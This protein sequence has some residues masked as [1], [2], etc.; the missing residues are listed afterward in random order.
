MRYWLISVIQIPIPY[1]VVS[2]S[3]FKSSRVILGNLVPYQVGYKGCGVNACGSWLPLIEHNG[4]LLMRIQGYRLIIIVNLNII[5]IGYGERHVES[6]VILTLIPYS[7]LNIDPTS[8]S[9]FRIHIHGF[10]NS[11]VF[12]IHLNGH[13]INIPVV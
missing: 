11:I 13:L 5:L 7:T 9:D 3:N 1:Q 8:R 12:A 2:Y 6:C 4:L 10:C